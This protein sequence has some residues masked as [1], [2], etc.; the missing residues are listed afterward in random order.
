[1]KEYVLSKLKMIFKLY[2]VIAMLALTVLSTQQIIAQTPA[3]F[4]WKTL[5][6]A[7]GVPLIFESING[8]TN[9]FD[10]SHNVNPGAYVSATM[11]MVGYAKFLPLFDRAAM[12]SV[13]FPMGHI[14][15]EVIAA[16]LTSKETAKGFGDP[17]LEFDINIIG[18]KAQMSLP[19]LMRYEPGFSLDLIMDI[20]FPVGEY[21]NTKSLNLGQNRWYGR[22][23]AP[24]VWQIG[25]WI[26]GKRTTLEFLPAVWLLGDNTDYLGKTL[27]TDP[28]FQLDAHLSRDLT[29]NFWASLDGAWF[30]GGQSSV[31]TSEGTKLN[32]IALGITLGYQINE[33]INL[34]FGYKSTINDDEPDALR[35]DG[36]MVT[37]VY[38][39]HPL[40]EGVK[41]LKESE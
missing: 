5:S 10:P 1:M 41:R 23:G 26:P 9:P 33:N 34:T 38:G 15:S 31:D 2:A 37:L 3:H 4:Y 21:D 6:G 11:A 25:P 32:N 35:M 16:G 39:W 18:P 19:D 36:F 20:A 28:L 13:V 22:L 17:M 27:Q 7:N 30:N 24:I 14:S 8:N 29:H 40:I 12:I